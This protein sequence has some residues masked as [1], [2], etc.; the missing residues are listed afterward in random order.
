MSSNNEV[1][2]RN[3]QDTADK[4]IQTHTSEPYMEEDSEE[5]FKKIRAREMMKVELRKKCF[6]C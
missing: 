1:T 2:Q 3:I 4:Y 6:S 5:S